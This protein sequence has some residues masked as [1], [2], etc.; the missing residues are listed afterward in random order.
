MHC[1]VG[2]Q[3]VVVE[4]EDKRVA[5]VSELVE[6]QR[7]R[8]LYDRQPGRTQHL[9]RAL[10]QTGSDRPERSDHVRPEAD[11]VV[12]GA[13]ERKP[14][15]VRVT[16]RAPLRKQRRL[17][18]AGPGAHDNQPCLTQRKLLEQ[19]KAGDEFRARPRRVQLG[20]EE[21]RPRRG[22]Y[23]AP[24]VTR[25]TLQPPRARHQHSKFTRMKPSHG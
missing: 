20:R 2:D 22:L 6:Q 18:P 1:G 23:A 17:P 19:P 3:V 15:E 16:A 13:V 21:N 9:E 10:A 7:Q 11:R 24:S 14:G 5:P 4:D 8:A 12:V 25:P